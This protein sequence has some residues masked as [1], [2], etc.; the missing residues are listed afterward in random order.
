MYKTFNRNY[1]T[2]FIFGFSTPMP[3]ACSNFKFSKCPTLAVNFQMANAVAEAHE[4]RSPTDVQWRARRFLGCALRSTRVTCRVRV[5]ARSVTRPV[6]CSAG[7]LSRFLIPTEG[8]WS[9]L[10]RSDGR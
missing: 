3:P 8:N 7:I 10:S 4:R 2:I 1:S 5:R 9:C 6:R